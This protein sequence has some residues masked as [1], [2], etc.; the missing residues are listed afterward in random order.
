MR[1]IHKVTVWTTTGYNIDARPT[2]A[3]PVVV[4]ARWEDVQRLYATAAGDQATSKAMVYVDRKVAVGSY[5]ALGV[6]ADA[7]PPSQVAHEVKALRTIES[8][9]GTDVEYRVVL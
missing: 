5:I 6:F 3:A 1:F 4:D 7:E 9:L 8:L 2:W